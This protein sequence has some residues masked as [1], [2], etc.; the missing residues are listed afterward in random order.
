MNATVNNQ[1]FPL[2]RYLSKIATP[3]LMRL[4][5]SANQITA[6]SLVSGLA[7]AWCLIQGKMAW[8]ISAG[9]LFVITYVLDNCDGEIAR[10]KDQC[11]EFGMRFDTFVDWAVH[12]AFFAALGIGV[13]GRFDNDLWLW[14]GMIAAA[15]GTINYGVSFYLDAHE[16][17]K[18][19]AEAI[20]EGG[21][22]GK[23]PE[24]THR[25]PEGLSDWVL[26]AFR[27][28]TRADFCFIVLALAVFDLT[29]FLLPT[30]A[31]GAHAYWATQFIRGARD[32]HV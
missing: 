2:I 5:V 24:K 6:A 32:H 10:L 22:E 12:T 23:R 20:R 25:E 21:G 28:L 31:V 18:T 13:A 1:L 9:A 8:D 7:A 14:M 4:P 26:Y 3:V 16:K 19:E 27:E 15:G 30:A 11:S 17:A 29:W